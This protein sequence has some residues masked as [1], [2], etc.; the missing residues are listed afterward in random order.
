MQ[1][2][3]TVK[4]TPAD[5]RD[6]QLSIDTTVGPAVDVADNKSRDKCHRR[7]VM[8][9]RKQDGASFGLAEASQLAPGSLSC[10]PRTSVAVRVLDSVDVRTVCSVC[11]FNLIKF[12]TLNQTKWT[13]CWLVG[14]SLPVDYIRPKCDISLEYE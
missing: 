10:G 3:Q 5:S 2:Q 9:N 12:K 7:Q 13:I 14:G 1:I 8:T 11:S 4:H 6:K